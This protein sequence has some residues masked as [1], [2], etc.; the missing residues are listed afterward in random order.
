MMVVK[1]V[2]LE[3]ICP[4]GLHP[5][6]WA[7]CVQLVPSCSLLL[8]LSVLCCVRGGVPPIWSTLF[9]VP[10]WKWSLGPYQMPNPLATPESWPGKF[11]FAIN[12]LVSG[13]LF[14][15]C[16]QS[17]R[18]HLNLDFSLL[19]QWKL[20]SKSRSSWQLWFWP[21]KEEVRDGGSLAVWLC[22]EQVE[23]FQSG[24]PWWMRLWE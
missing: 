4:R 5:W 6:G 23:V 10:S 19:C 7:W 8:S 1:W 22:G 16:K 2:F 21:W 9:R 13:I 18:G 11:L 17:K 20:T 3:A 24:L 14:Q 12:F 15:Q